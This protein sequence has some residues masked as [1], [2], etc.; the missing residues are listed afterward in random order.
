MNLRQ[1]DL[2][3]L[4]AL[5][6]LLSDCNITEAGRRIHVTQS[7]MSGS[8]GRLREFFGDELLVPAGRRM[9]PTPLAESLAQPVREALLQIKT[10]LH[11]KPQFDPATSNRRFSLMM[12]D[13]VATVLMPEVLKRAEERAPSVS[14]EVQSNDV[15]NPHEVV[16]RADVDFLIMP[17]HFL[18]AEHPSEPLYTEGYA[19]LAWRDN[20]L[21]G[22]SLSREQYCK[23]GHVMLQYRT[24]A[25][26]LDEWFLSKSGIVRRAEVL[27]SSF[28]AVPQLV[29]GTKR[30]ATVHRRLAEFYAQY[31]PLKVLAVPYEIPQVIE[32]LQWHRCFTDAPGHRWLHQLLVDAAQGVVR[33]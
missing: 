11:A 2:N 1:L 30:I 16:D 24:R 29:V 10:V 9:I 23:L 15:A 28:N 32:A 17:E 25:A 8:L 12:S 7:T 33:H 31:H 5:D 6:A 4:V 18:S 27:A 3:L 13:Y 14:F 21:V 20:P 22:S 19:C 26:F